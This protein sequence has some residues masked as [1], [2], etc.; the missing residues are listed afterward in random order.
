M[1]AMHYDPPDTGDLEADLTTALTQLKT[2]LTKRKVRPIF[3]ALVEY[4]NKDK[5]FVAA[6]R[7]FVEGLV[8]PTLEVLQQ[9]QERGDLQ[10]EIDCVVLA[11]TAAGT[12]LHQYLVMHGSIKDDLIDSAVSN[13]IDFE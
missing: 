6:Q 1:V 7:K 10:Q 13:T 12:L 5:A 3:A 2:R 4:A 11:N 9:A 8:Q